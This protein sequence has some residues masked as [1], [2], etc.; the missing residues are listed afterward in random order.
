MFSHFYFILITNKYFILTTNNINGKNIY[1]FDQM[2]PNRE[3]NGLRSSVDQ[4]TDVV[5]TYIIFITIELIKDQ[6][7]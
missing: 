3:S 1:L 2:Y 4:S 6:I 7:A 5:P